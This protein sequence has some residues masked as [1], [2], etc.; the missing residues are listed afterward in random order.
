MRVF[1]PQLGCA[2][3]SAPKEAVDLVVVTESTCKD[4]LQGIRTKTAPYWDLEMNRCADES[5]K[6]LLT[7]CATKIGS[8]FST[9]LQV[10]PIPV[11]HDGQYANSVPADMLTVSF[12][13]FPLLRTYDAGALPLR[14]E[15]F[16]LGFPQTH[17]RIIAAI[18]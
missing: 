17:D 10:C 3:L 7:Q 4:V 11:L 14:H 15:S 6:G 12:V 1:Q 8:N 18:D 5:R 9:S 16:G 2:Q 13:F